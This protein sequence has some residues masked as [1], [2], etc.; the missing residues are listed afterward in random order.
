MRKRRYIKEKII[1]H[2][3][4]PIF[5]IIL[6]CLRLSYFV[7]Y[8]YKNIICNLLI[9]RSKTNEVSFISIVAIKMHLVKNTPMP[10]GLG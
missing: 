7:N 8:A 10:S 6:F 9:V 2:T 3:K 4:C 1:T 5:I